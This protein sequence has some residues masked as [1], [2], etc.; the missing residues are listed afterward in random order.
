LNK[1]KSKTDLC[2][3]ESVFVISAVMPRRGITVTGIFCIGKSEKMEERKGYVSHIVFRNVENGYTVFELENADGDTETCVGTIPFISEGE[4][5][6]VK[7]QLV[8]HPVYM[9][10]LKVESFE[11]KEPDNEIAMLRYLSS[12]AITG[13][14]GG[15]AKRIVDKFG[16]K[17]FDIIEKEPERLAE[18][19]GISEK[20]AMAIA[21]QFEEKR[22]MRAAMIFLQQYGISNQ[23]AVKI[24]QAYGAGL[25]AVVK[26]NPYKLAEDITG[27]GFKIA[28]E[29]A[30]HSGFNP[31][32]EQRIRAGILYVLNNGSQE[33]YV[34]MPEELLLKQAVYCL[35]VSQESILHALETM[36]V[37][38][39]VIQTEEHQ[40]YLP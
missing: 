13:I 38:K 23:L 12:G 10:Q 9:E 17:T 6:C 40:I 5:A 11:T 20:K 30:K 1:E 21:D 4:Y 3:H 39:T 32:S 37:D 8:Q 16:E 27:V 35:E 2:Q 19:K 15:L 14:R 25:Y 18:I 22:E 28:D 29:I 34:Y 7:G 36:A 26:E 24:Y 31:D 33:G